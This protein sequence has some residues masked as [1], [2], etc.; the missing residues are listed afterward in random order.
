METWIVT[1][2][3]QKK[4]LDQFI[5]SRVD[6]SRTKVAEMIKDGHVLV[7]HT[8]QKA[9]YKVKEHDHIQFGDYQ[10]KQ[11]HIRGHTMALDIVYEDDD[12]IVINK[13]SGLVVHP[14]KGVTDP[15]LLHGLVDYFKRNHYQGRPGLVHRLDRDTSGLLVIAK[16]AVSHDR[17]AQQLSNKT[18]YREYLALVWGHPTSCVVD[19]PIGPSMDGNFQMCVDPIHGKP[20]RTHFTHIQDFRDSSLISCRLDTGRTHQIRVHAQHAGFP[21]LEDPRY[22]LN[23]AGNGQYLCAHKITFIHPMTQQIMHF[24]IQLPDSFQRKIE[25]L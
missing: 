9:N 4:R 20:A 8:K 11:M 5:N 22:Y 14:A 18:M 12:L 25:T 16:H 15:T 6:L 1:A 13:P 23:Q 17:L 19:A 2:L 21:L 3:D 10:A 7:N 24:S